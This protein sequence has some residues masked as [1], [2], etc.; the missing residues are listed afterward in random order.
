MFTEQ[1]FTRRIREYLEEEHLKGVVNS[2]HH[3]LTN[4]LILHYHNVSPLRIYFVA[5]WRCGGINI[6][7]GRPAD[8]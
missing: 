6:L 3:M 4:N 2:V 5:E 7:Q 8:L 1:S